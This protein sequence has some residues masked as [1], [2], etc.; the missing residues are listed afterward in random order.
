MAGALADCAGFAADTRGRLEGLAREGGLLAAV[1][2]YEAIDDHLGRL[3]SYAG[4]VYA[5]D[6]TDPAR[7]KFYGD[8]QDKATRAASDLLFF[9]LELNRIADAVLDAAALGELAPYRP[10]L[11]D[12]RKDKPFQLA[13]D[14]EKLFLEKS[15]TGASA[16]NRLF[17]ETLA[18]IRF[19]VEGADLALEPTLSLLQDADGGKRKAAAQGLSEGLAA[20]IRTFSLITNVLA[21][22]KEIAD[23]WRGFA[24]I[25]DSR[26]LANRVEREVVDALSDAVTAAYPRLSH[27]YYRLK[28]RWFGVASLPV[29]AAE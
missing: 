28:A 3:M 10:W 19:P 22:D 15:A 12:L 6:T 9:P 4:L 2:R 24:D 23:R 29:P 18:A 21:K 5:E 14:I 26:H 16:W 1:R 20:N 7:T 13:D 8:A 25:A 27:R 11:D 17:D